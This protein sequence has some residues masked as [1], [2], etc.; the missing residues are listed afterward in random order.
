MLRRLAAFD[1]VIVARSDGRFHEYDQ[2]YGTK[3]QL[4]KLTSSVTK[5]IDQLVHR[6]EPAP[7]SLLE[8]GCGQGDL[9]AAFV[10]RL[11]ARGGAVSALGV[12]GSTGA[13]VTCAGRYPKL[14]WAADSLEHFLATHDEAVRDRE[15][16]LQRY[17]LVLDKTG[18][19]FIEEFEAARAYFARVDALM[20]P[21]AVYV[22]IASRNYYEEVLRKKNYASWPED[23]M[24]LAAA[25]WEP[26]FADDDA[27]PALRGYY[28]RVFRKA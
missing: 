10:R 5:F 21:G 4:Y 25:T 23:W 28:K 1:N 11:Q 22:Y 12:D 24:S 16:Q 14:R 15:D 8:V 27:G 13:I 9:L 20:R 19:I 26:W 3:P 6:L 17:D 7:R 2:E 18:A